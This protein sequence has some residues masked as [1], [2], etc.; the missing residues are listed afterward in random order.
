MKVYHGSY[1]EI[2]EIDLN[3]CEVGK[4]FGR[5]F[6]VTN[7]YKQ[8][9]IWAK[10]K[11]KFNRTTGIV[12]EFDFNENIPKI[13]KLNV[14][15]FVEYND[16]WLEFVVLNRLNERDQQAHDYDIIEGPV[17]D[18]KVAE[19]IDD[20]IAG[21][22]SQKD[23]LNDL[24]YNPSHQIC[25][26]TIQSLQALQLSKEKI[27]RAKRLIDKGILQALI[28]DYGINEMSA[29]DK[30]YTSKTYTQLA[31]ETTQF[32]K[33]DWCEIYELLKQELKFR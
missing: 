13:M 27:D 12:T 20:Y 32:Y 33:K 23:F 5:G 31:D 15:K 24:V 26:C 30:Y 10:R 17:A 1:T 4:D 18:D 29:T 3:F 16:E 7:L 19:Q 28:T 11:G 8:A 9:E 22:L 21:S 6:Y 2:D 25:F 14:L